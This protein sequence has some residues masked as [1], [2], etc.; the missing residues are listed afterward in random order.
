[1]IYCYKVLVITILFKKN[2]AYVQ[3]RFQMKVIG[4]FKF[5]KIT[6]IIIY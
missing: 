5:G 1:M 4:P 2:S 3:R 6:K